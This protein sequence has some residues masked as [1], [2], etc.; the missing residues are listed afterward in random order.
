MTTEMPTTERDRA[1]LDLLYAISR[2]LAAQLDLRELLRRVLRLTI[3]NVGAATGSILQGANIPQHG[4]VGLVD[5]LAS[6]IAAHGGSVA[7]AKRV[8]GLSVAGS[9][10][11]G[12]TFADGSEFPSDLVIST[13]SPRLTCNLIP[14]C[15]VGEFSY[16]PSNSLVSCF[17]RISGY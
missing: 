4:F 8:T 17:V 2:E 9:Q 11:R 14:G 1:S 16:R 7:T 3:E 13:L 5:A 6:V 12:V 15:E 10:V